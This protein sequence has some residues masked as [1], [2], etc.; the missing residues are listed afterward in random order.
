MTLTPGRSWQIVRDVW[1]DCRSFSLEFAVPSRSSLE[2]RNAGQAGRE[3]E[4]ATGSTAE[5][6]PPPVRLWQ[7]EVHVP[8]IYDLEVDT[9]L[10]SAEEC[11]EL[12]RRRLEDGPPA[13]AF[14]QLAEGLQSQAP[15]RSE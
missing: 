12:I 7:R 6:I 14:R 10:L 5:P 8:G 4:Y 3:G 13:S 2:R 9:S 11:A 1:R 15:R